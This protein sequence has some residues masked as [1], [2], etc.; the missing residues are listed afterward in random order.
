MSLRRYA[1]TVEYADTPLRRNLGIRR[2][3]GTVEYADTPLRRNFVLRQ[4]ADTLFLRRYAQTSLV[5]NRPSI[6]VRVNI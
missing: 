3:A 5:V 1:G 6:Y 4:Y 2:Y